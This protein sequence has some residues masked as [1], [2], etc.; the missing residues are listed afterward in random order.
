MRS[1]GLCLIRKYFLSH[2]FLEIETPYLQTAPNLDPHVEP[3]S[4]SPDGGPFLHTSPEYQMKKALAAGAGD[5]F[6][7]CRVFRKDPK[8]PW[9]RR[10]FTMLEWYRVGQDYR[11]LMEDAKG[12]IMYLVKEL[13]LRPPKI[14]L[15]GPWLSLTVSEAFKKFAGIDPMDMD[16]ST[17]RDYLLS[18][19]FKISPQDPWETCFHYLFVAQVEPA[20]AKLDTPV[21]LSH[22]PA[23]LSV[24][25]R[26][27]PQDPRV[28]ERIELYIGGVEL[29]NGY[30]ELT[31]PKE[32]RRRLEAE[33]KTRNVSWPLDEELLEALAHMPPAAGAAMGLDRLL[34]VLKGER[35]IGRFMLE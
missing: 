25:A 1:R 32:Q 17:F 31:D 30:S 15:E 6:Q 4:L 26:L 13:R 33:R 34:T 10:E 29:M 9:H 7:I 19:G 11:V 28:C 20:L 23:S 16:E 3:F 5:I 35:D 21:F 2:G 12:L 27:S 22:Y 24:M 8:T 18:K 14:N